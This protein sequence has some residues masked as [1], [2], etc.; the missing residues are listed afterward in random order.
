MKP[1]ALLFLLPAL[2]LA[3][4]DHGTEPGKDVHEAV[5]TGNGAWTFEA[6]PHWGELPDGKNLDP[7]PSIAILDGVHSRLAIVLDSLTPDQFERTATHP[8]WGAITVD[9]LVQMY[10]WHCRHHVAHIERL[11][12]REGWR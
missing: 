4:P 12:E 10:A 7:A 11:R 2:A 1:A 3:H 5:R 9:F 6:V 8:Q